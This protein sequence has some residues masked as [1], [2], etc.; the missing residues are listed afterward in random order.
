MNRIVIITALPFRLKGNQSLLRFVKM[1][2]S[3]GDEVIFFTTGAD[4]NGENTL[5]D[6]LFSYRKLKSFK[7]MVLFIARNKKIKP[8]TGLSLPEESIYL[9]LRSE[10]TL[11]PFGYHNLKN[12][13][14]KWLNTL[15]LIFENLYLFTYLVLF[16]NRV[17]R[18]ADALVAYEYDNAIAAKWLSVFFRKVLI[19]KYQG[20][21]LKASNRSVK[22]C[23]FFY[24][25]NYIGLIKSDLCVMVND[26]TDGAYYA[27]KKGNQ[28]ILFITHGVQDQSLNMSTVSDILEQSNGK[29]IVFNNASGSF[30]KRVDRTM[31]FINLLSDDVKKNIIVY[32]TYYGPYVEHIE[33]FIQELGIMENF[34]LLKNIDSV[35]SN[36]L[37]RAANVL[38]M[39][40]DLSNLGNPVLEALYYGTPVITIKDEVMADFVESEAHG[41]LIPLDKNFDQVLAD[42][43]TKRYHDFIAGRGTQVHDRIQNNHHNVFSLLEQQEKEYQAISNVITKE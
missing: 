15:V 41:K 6:P 43:I 31:R 20:V 25:A 2:I 37:L 30:W 38:V 10:E 33:R 27:K 29:F 23:Y 12:A 1:F 19:S 8:I 32:S 26:G 17:I 9:T 35:Q 42:E 18:N 40:N 22:E 7:Q 36:A 39:T 5:R 11:P 34:V 21:I 28:N 16:E 13:L 3:R 14:V 24:P 4:N